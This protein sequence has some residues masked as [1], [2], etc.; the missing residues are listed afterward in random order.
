MA[1]ARVVPLH[2]DQQQPKRFS[3]SAA[4]TPALATGTDDD[5]GH[6]AVVRTF[7]RHYSSLKPYPLNSGEALFVIH[8]MDF[9]WGDDAPW[10]SYAKLAAYMG[11]SPKMAR[12][13][14]QSLQV[15]GYLHREIRRA[16]TNRF[17]LRPLFRALETKVF[18]KVM[19][20]GL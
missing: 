2:P 16:M 8:L 5:H 20:A 6:V 3:A 12:R 19:T 4:W 7:L 10:P 15:K 14:A 18:G 11:I 13:H 9:K 1:R 17:D